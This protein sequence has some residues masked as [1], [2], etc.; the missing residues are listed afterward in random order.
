MLE[1]IGMTNLKPGNNFLLSFSHLVFPFTFW[2]RLFGF[3]CFKNVAFT[4]NNMEKED[5]Y[6]IIQENT[7][8]YHTC[9]STYRWWRKNMKSRWLWNVTTLRPRKFG[10]CG[11]SDCI[12]LRHINNSK[13]CNSILNRYIWSLDPEWSRRNTLADFRTNNKSSNMYNYNI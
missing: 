3:F 1:R 12:N 11:N 2:F 10:S 5:T 7:E 13:I 6:V 4:C 9:T 8:Q